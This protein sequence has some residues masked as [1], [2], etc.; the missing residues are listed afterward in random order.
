MNKSGKLFGS[1]SFHGIVKGWSFSSYPEI[2]GN[3]GGF[4]LVRHFC[5]EPEFARQKGRELSSAVS[6]KETYF[7]E[8]DFTFRA[9]SFRVMRR[10]A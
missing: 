7:C 9:D 10:R 6:M 4:R 1:G 5:P 3:D 8:K 2:R